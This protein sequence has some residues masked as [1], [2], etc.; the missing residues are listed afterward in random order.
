MG[1]HPNDHNRYLLRRHFEQ[2]DHEQEITSLPAGVQRE[3]ASVSPEQ[4]LRWA[5]GWENGAVTPD[6]PG[7]APAESFNWKEDRSFDLHKIEGWDAGFYDGLYEHAKQRIPE[8]EEWGTFVYFNGM[9]E[10][11]R[12]RTIE[13]I[14]VVEGTDGQFYVW[15]GNHRVGIAH[16]LDVTT[17][18]A[19]VGYPKREEA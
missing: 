12:N 11:I 17:M 13:E 1:V 3:I 10:A 18:P 7:Y 15:E 16:V 5:K 8:D 9:C 19:F 4:I 2:Y 14:F 6:S